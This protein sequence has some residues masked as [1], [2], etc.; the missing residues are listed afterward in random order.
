M[1]PNWPGEKIGIFS[2]FY[3]RAVHALVPLKNYLFLL[4]FNSIHGI[5]RDNILKDLNEGC[6]NNA[7]SVTNLF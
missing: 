5:F 1:S 2:V 7:V 3:P 6:K 4:M